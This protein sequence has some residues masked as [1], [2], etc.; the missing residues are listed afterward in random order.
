[1]M[2]EETP[3]LR[4]T[5]CKLVTLSLLEVFKDVIPSYQIKHQDNPGVKC[6]VCLRCMPHTDYIG[7]D[8]YDKTAIAEGF[9]VLLISI[10]L[11]IVG[12]PV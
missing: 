5:V 2:N 7:L 1:M 6:K 3:E 8:T 10:S 9:D 12:H 4:I 11:S